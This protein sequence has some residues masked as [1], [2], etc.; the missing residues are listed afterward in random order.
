MKY[1][2]LCL[3]SFEL[4]YERT[5]EIEEIWEDLRYTYTDHRYCL[6]SDIPKD[7]ISY[8]E[9]KIVTFMSLKKAE[10]WI[11]IYST[12]NNYPANLFEI[13]RADG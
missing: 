13:V 1:Q 12:E 3:E 5:V 10:K 7:A 4:L 6:S 2:I 11:K 8:S 9:A